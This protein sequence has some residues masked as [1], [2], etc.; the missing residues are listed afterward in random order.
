ME[1][2]EVSP[3]HVLFSF[4]GSGEYES[5]EHRHGLVSVS[6]NDIVES[7]LLPALNL[8][9]GL[10]TVRDSMVDMVSTAVKQ[11]CNVGPA[12]AALLTEVLE[13]TGE[14]RLA[15]TLLRSKEFGIQLYGRDEINLAKVIVR[16]GDCHGDGQVSLHGIDMLKRIG[17]DESRGE[18]VRRYLREGDFVGAIREGRGGKRGEG[19]PTSGDFWRAAIKKAEGGGEEENMEEG[20]RV[21][22]LYLLFVFLK[23]YENTQVNTRIGKGARAEKGMGKRRGSKK[24]QEKS[25]GLRVESELAKEVGEFPPGLIKNKQ[26]V[27]TLKGMFGFAS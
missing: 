2:G 16:I 21:R 23:E 12:I 13:R 22:L 27:N 11:G 26:V 4:A 5:L 7:V 8:P 6:Q 3:S 14:G 10:Q 9:D 18:I 24:E 15:V 17:N 25:K 1:G 20:E 19:W